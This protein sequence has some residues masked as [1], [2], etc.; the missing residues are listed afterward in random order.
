MRYKDPFTLR[1]KQA[2]RNEYDQATLSDLV[3]HT[4]VSNQNHKHSGINE[5]CQSIALQVSNDKT[6]V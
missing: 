6:F 1:V 4:I 5:V 3:T 2:E